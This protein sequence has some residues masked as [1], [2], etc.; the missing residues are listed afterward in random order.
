LPL[1]GIGS[2]KGLWLKPLTFPCL[3][4]LLLLLFN[5]F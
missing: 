5:I 3:D 2:L 4:C 1:S